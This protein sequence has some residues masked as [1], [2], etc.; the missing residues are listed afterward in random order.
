VNSKEAP[1]SI[2]YQLTEL[3]LPPQKET[4]TLGRSG[5]AGGLCKGE[6]MRMTVEVILEFKAPGTE[7]LRIHCKK[8]FCFCPKRVFS[9]L[10]RFCHRRKTRIEHSCL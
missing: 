5:Q 9:N 6:Q 3:C 10:S 2:F 8:G 7:S 4:W 1:L